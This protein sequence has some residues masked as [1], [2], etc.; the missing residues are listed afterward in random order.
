MRGLLLKDFIMIV[1][2]MKTFLILILIFMIFSRNMS[3]VIIMALSII[4]PISAF[5]YDERA[6][7]D[8]F[9]VM[10]PISS[11]EIVRSKYI[12]AAISVIVVNGI[13]AILQVMLGSVEVDLA[14]R[15]L[16]VGVAFCAS[17]FVISI[18]VPFIIKFGSEKARIYLFVLIAGM[19]VLVGSIPNIVLD[20]SMDISLINGNV[21]WLSVLAGLALSPVAILISQKISVKIYEKKYE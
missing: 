17:V 18:Y 12:L 7:W 20:G 16:P 15:M 14:M 3:T 10:L 21:I 13:S 1:R 11:K 2:Q 5:A 19:S 9:C 6:R 4:V 8:D